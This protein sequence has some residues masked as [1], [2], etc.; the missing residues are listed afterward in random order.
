MR[1]R[2]FPWALSAL[3][4]VAL[5][6]CG[7]ASNPP[8]TRDSGSTESASDRSEASTSAAAPSTTAATAEPP[9]PY[10]YPRRDQQSPEGA[11]ETFQLF[12]DAV[13]YTRVSHD[14]TDLTNLSDPE[15]S[16]CSQE[17]THAAEA[18]KKGASWSPV[19][20]GRQSTT[21]V[22]CTPFSC[23]I[24]SD[25]TVPEHTQRADSSA[26]PATVGEQ[27]FSA[28]G[29]VRW[30]KDRWIVHSTTMTKIGV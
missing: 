29:E 2:L 14:T 15:C 30:K 27:R 28:S 1:N 12:W 23:I 19:S 6:A 3:L 25:F 21:V 5:S 11:K 24:R 18:K 9:N 13:I 20:L 22:S 16:L 7:S 10:A 26:A 4:V 17:I 8:S